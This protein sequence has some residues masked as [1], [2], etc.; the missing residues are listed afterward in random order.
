MRQA[1]ATGAATRPA[2]DERFMFKVFAVFALMAF[3][4]V[5]ISIGGKH[6]GRSIALAG[7]T[8]STRV[9]EIVIGNDVLRAPANAIRFERGRRDGVAANLQL[10]LRWPDMR[11]YS[12]AA[13]DDFNHAGGSRN[14]LFLSFEPRIMSRDM[15]GRLQ[16]IYRALIEP[17]AHEGP[18]G[19]ALHPFTAASGYLD[20]MLVV[21]PEEA[22]GRFVARCLTGPA[23]AESLADCERDLFVGEELVLVYRFPSSLLPQWRLLEA[24]VRAYADGA[25]QRVR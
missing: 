10:Y 16:P 24:S 21:G 4:A 20:E 12:A 9:H 22:G 13:R 7:H 25:I 6:I 14:I 18:G 17:R 23:A 2:F 1:E 11:G 3:A 19:L 5:L 15:S 8:E